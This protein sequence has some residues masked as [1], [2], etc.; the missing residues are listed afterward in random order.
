[1]YVC[2]CVYVSI[3]T[4]K[5]EKC[6]VRVDAVRS[7]HSTEDKYSFCYG[8]G[9]LCGYVVNLAGTPAEIQS[10]FME[11]NSCHFRLWTSRV[12]GCPGTRILHAAAVCSVLLSL[13][14]LDCSMPIVQIASKALHDA[15]D[16]LLGVHCI[17]RIT[18]PH[19]HSFSDPPT[20][21]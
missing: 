3:C 4:G 11:L 20:P 6:S 16:A 12:T 7:I 14:P 8:A 19:F 2:M 9:T 17:T 21:P 13:S 15:N 5:P 18:R 10:K 1:M